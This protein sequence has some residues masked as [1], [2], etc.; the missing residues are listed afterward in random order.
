MV[1]LILI[2]MLFLANIT[3]VI[4]FLIASSEYINVSGEFTDE[5]NKR[6]KPLIN[7]EILFNPW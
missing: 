2:E 7:K 5:R 4:V 6:S 1:E 3:F